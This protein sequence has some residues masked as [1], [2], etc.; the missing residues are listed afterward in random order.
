MNCSRAV[1]WREQRYFNKLIKMAAQIQDVS[2]RPM[3]EQDLAE[4]RRIFRTAFGTFLGAPNPEEFWSD[5]EYVFT[6]WNNSATS[7]LVAALKHGLAGSNFV[8]RWGSFGF[9]GPLTVRPDLWDQGIARKLLGPTMELFAEWGIRD[10]A[11]FTFAHSSK[12]ICLYQKYGFWPGY[13]TAIM[14]KPAESG[15]ASATKFSELNLEQQTEALSACRELTGSILEGLDVSGEIESVNRQSLG[16]TLLLWN[17]DALSAFAVCHCGVG[18]EA[19]SDCC[20]I[21]FAAVRPGP[22]AERNFTLLLDG[23]EALA[24]E[25]GLGRIE[26]GVNVARRTAYRQ[27]LAKGFR[28]QIQGVAMHCPDSPGYDRPDVLVIDDLR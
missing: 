9:F 28:T 10:A 16:D 22:A 25:R 8:T 5:R 11:L 6:R 4:A 14:F 27:M 18:T 19:G 13:L 21:K 2:V 7:G 20:Y 3:Q 1:V 12:H 17:R 26:A 24:T 23:C 15:K